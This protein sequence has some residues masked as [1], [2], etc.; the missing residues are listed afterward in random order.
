M[1]IL[2]FREDQECWE[3]VKQAILSKDK[4]DQEHPKLNFDTIVGEFGYNMLLMVRVHSQFVFNLAETDKDK[5]MVTV[6][7]NVVLLFSSS[8][9]TVQRKEDAKLGFEQ[10]NMAWD[11][12]G[13]KEHFSKSSIWASDQK[14]PNMPCQIKRENGQQEEVNYVVNYQQGRCGKKEKLLNI[15]HKFSL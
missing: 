2:A 12:G 8:P 14:F 11:D 7:K 13:M 1:N 10:S 3:G 5:K 9:F 6:P 15:N 4:I